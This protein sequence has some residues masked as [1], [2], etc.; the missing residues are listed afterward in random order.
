[1]VSGTTIGTRYSPKSEIPSILIDGNPRNTSTPRQ[2]RKSKTPRP[3]TQYFFV[4]WY[5]VV[6]ELHSG[7]G[8]WPLVV[9]LKLLLHKLL[10]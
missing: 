5:A 9:G 2:T 8:G 10:I 4:I 1:M 6:L 3:E 7:H